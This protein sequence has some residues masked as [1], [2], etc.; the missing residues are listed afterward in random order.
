[1]GQQI[2]AKLARPRTERLR[3]GIRVVLAGPV[4][5]GKSSL[6]NALVGRDQAIVSDQAG[7]TRDVIEVSL[8]LDGLPFLLVDTAGLRTSS[9]VVEAVGVERAQSQ[10]A[11]ADILL[12]LG[13]ALEAPVHRRRIMVFGRA[14]V[15]SASDMPDGAIAVSVRTG[16]GITEL[17]DRLKQQARGLL[18]AEGEAAINARQA[19]LL[20]EVAD[21]LA[22]SSEQDLVLTAEALRQA[23]FAM[24]RVVGRAGIEDV[25]E[26]LFGRF[27]LGK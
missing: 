4:N 19:N 13:D 12:W 11:A 9:D 25:L 17:L 6:L 16:V 23:R 15:R 27:C 20:T 24:D 8:A 5:S 26:S 1:L 2:R 22:L 10:V 3:E 7:T 18:P 21:A 14:D